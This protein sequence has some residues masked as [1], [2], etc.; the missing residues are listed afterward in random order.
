ML[1]NRMRVPSCDHTGRPKS[2]P[3]NGMATCCS[4]FPRGRIVKACEPPPSSCRLN[5]IRAALLWEAWWEC[6]VALADDGGALA[7]APRTSTLTMTKRLIAKRRPWA[8]IIEFLL[9][10]RTQ[11]S[12]FRSIVL[13]KP[14][15]GLYRRNILEILHRGREFSV[16][17]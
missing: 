9:R 3:A 17:L 14:C 11:S 5:A 4:S 10:P 15:R 2:S 16:R 7:T 1:L 6:G 8:G 12:P 13:T